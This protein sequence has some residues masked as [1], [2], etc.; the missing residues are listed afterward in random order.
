MSGDPELIRRMLLN[1]LDNGIKFTPTGGRVQLEAHLSG[2]Q[3]TITVS[4]TG[5]GIPPA[6][7]D[8]I[9]DRFFRVDEARS[10]QGGAGLGLAI[11]RWIARAH[12]GDL[13]LLRSNSE[14]SVFQATLPI[15]A[16]EAAA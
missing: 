7:Q 14:G 10:R 9:F 2:P 1:L 3:Y 16:N 13:R 15:E 6:D 4:D 11:A 5:S 8:R 12:G